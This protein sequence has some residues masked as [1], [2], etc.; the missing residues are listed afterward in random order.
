MPWLEDRKEER[1]QALADR[2]KL[3]KQFYPIDLAF[4]SMFDDAKGSP[5]TAKQRDII[6]FRTVLA[7]KLGLLGRTIQ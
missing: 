7:R 4:R 1:R 3:W 5:Y 6:H 2:D